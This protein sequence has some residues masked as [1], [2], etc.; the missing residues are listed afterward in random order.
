MLGPKGPVFL[1]AECAWYGDPAFDAAFCLKHLLLKCLW[2]PGSTADFLDCFNSLWDGYRN[3]IDWEPEADVAHRVATLLPGQ[4]RVVATTES[5]LRADHSLEV[6]ADAANAY[7]RRIP[8]ERPLTARA[9][10][11]DW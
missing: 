1:D 6:G 2:T 11:Q 7:A 9:R 10:A 5:G 4:Y 8:L 3:E